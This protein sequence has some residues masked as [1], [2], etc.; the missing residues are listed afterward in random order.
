MLG[1]FRQFK[2]FGFVLKMYFR[3][4]QLFV[5]LLDI[6]SIAVFVTRNRF[7]KKPTCA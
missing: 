2:F 3:F 5:F 7:V 1:S 4:P 6:L